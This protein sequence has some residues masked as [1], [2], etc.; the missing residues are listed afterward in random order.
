MERPKPSKQLFIELCGGNQGLIESVHHGLAETPLN[1]LYPNL[2][3]DEVLAFEASSWKTREKN[4]ASF[5]DFVKSA[6][7][8]DIFSEVYKLGFSWLNKHKN[9]SQKLAKR[10]SELNPF[11]GENLRSRLEK[12]KP[13]DI[14]SLKNKLQDGVN[15]YVF[16]CQYHDAKRMRG[17]DNYKLSVMAFQNAYPK[18]GRIVPAFASQNA[19]M[20][21]EY[22]TDYELL[23]I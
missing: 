8:Y 19:R 21:S 17:G 18:S 9:I 12:A 22:P 14:D 20:L 11:N 15:A 23:S 7:I 4:L 2:D 13:E 6:G 10:H 3:L 16:S 1:A 5:S